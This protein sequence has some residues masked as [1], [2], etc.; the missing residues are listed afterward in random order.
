[1]NLDLISKGIVSLTTARDLNETSIIATNLFT[2]LGFNSW[3]CSPQPSGHFNSND[4]RLL[5]GKIIKE[6][7]EYYINND[8]RNKDAVLRYVIKAKKSFTFNSIYKDKTSLPEQGVREAAKQFGIVDGIA[9]PIYRGGGYFA[10]FFITSEKIV[11]IE[12]AQVEMMTLFASLLHDK[13][14]EL[15]HE[16]IFKIN[17]LKHLSARERDVL[18]WVLEGKSNNEIA[19]I[20]GISENTVKYHI[21]QACSRLGLKSRIQVAVKALVCGLLI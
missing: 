11:N 3:V 6:W 5:E 8:L 7:H 14:Y 2:E 13:I 21:K 4:L 12:N 20:I 9:I 10:A 18:I 1:M 17:N 15:R 16:D 19:K